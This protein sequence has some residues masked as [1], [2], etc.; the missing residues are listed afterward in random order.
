MKRVFLLIVFIMLT[1]TIFADMEKDFEQ[2]SKRLIKNV[3]DLKNEIIAVV[4]FDASPENLGVVVSDIYA[5]FLRDA[6]LK[7]V[8]RKQLQDVIDEVKLALVGITDKRNQDVL[9]KLLGASLLLTGTVGELGDRYVIN[10]KL[11]DIST[12]ITLS[13]DSV[14]VNRKDIITIKNLEDLFAEKK[15]PLTGAL[16]S[17][18]IPGWGQFYN[19]Q[20]IKG[21]LF[22]GLH[23]ASLG[24]AIYNFYEWQLH[25]NST[26]EGDEYARE[27]EL[28]REAY[29][30]M[31]ISL[32][33]S[34]LNWLGSII[35]GYT[36][37]FSNYFFR[38]E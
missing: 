10:A 21:I 11:I 13:Q 25:I 27:I 32:V 4:T 8:D 17:A 14:Y 28:A 5:Y 38:D 19:D 35:D 15:Y 2:S 30:R 22:M 36:N 31:Q 9:G 24:Y 18:L 7:I 1:L 12:G 6:G 29:E 26:A 34:F 20:P 3:P 16:R 37:G 23:G 33:I